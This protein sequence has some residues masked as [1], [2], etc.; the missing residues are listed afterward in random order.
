MPTLNRPL[1]LLS[2]SLEHPTSIET[3][4]GEP[5]L[6]LDCGLYQIRNVSEFDLQGRARYQMI[7]FNTSKT[8]ILDGCVS[9]NLISFLFAHSLN[10]GAFYASSYVS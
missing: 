1:A 2:F 8:Q 4:E 10:Q 6:T 3:S 9:Q 7:H 5:S